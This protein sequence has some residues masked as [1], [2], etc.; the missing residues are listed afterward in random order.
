MEEDNPL[1]P[2]QIPVW[3]ETLAKVDRRVE[4]KGR[5]EYFVPEPALIIGPKDPKSRRRYLFNWVKGRDP[6]LYIMTHSAFK[7]KPIHQQWWRNYLNHTNLHEASSG[8]THTAK[9]KAEVLTLFQAISAESPGA[10]HGDEVLFF[11]KPFSSTEAYCREVLWKVF[12]MGFRLELLALDR[13]LV[14][15]P[16]VMSHQSQVF[17]YERHDLISQVFSND[18]LLR[19]A[20]LPTENCGLAAENIADRLPALEAFRIVL[21]RWP[22]VPQLLCTRKFA[23]AVVEPDLLDLERCAVKFYLDTFYFH[24]S[25]AALVPHRFPL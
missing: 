2:P 1:F 19:V 18:G 15:A 10:I 22:G 8:T 25:R 20:S 24:S 13:V 5:I 11:G 21:V 7:Q 16:S 14:P 23:K 12:D 3:S 17:E 9:E 6:W 4:P